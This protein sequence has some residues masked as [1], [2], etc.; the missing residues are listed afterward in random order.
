MTTLLAGAAGATLAACTGN[1]P[2]PVA[3][4]APQQ[5][6]GPTGKSS[7]AP[8]VS[9]SAAIPAPANDAATRSAPV[10][11]GRPGRV[12]IFAGVGDSCEQLTAPEIT[13]L[14]TPQKGDV[15]FKPGQ[16]TTIA[17]SASGKCIGTKAT[18][19]GVYYTARAGMSGSDTF[20]VSA[21]MATGETMTRTFSVS[22]AE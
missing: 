5:E 20:A 21:R 9:S 2:S 16:M 6:S 1:A 11:P 4:A 14:Q 17:A 19:T 13:L 3:D 8:A 18:G 10:V 22:I 12:F 7:T 15:S